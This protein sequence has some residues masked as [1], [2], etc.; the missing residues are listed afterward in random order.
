MSETARIEKQSFHLYVIHNHFQ[1]CCHIILKRI[2]IYASININTHQH[3]QSLNHR[4]ML[5]HLEPLYL[6]HV[7]S[8][9][10]ER[11][12]VGTC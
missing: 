6:Y 3:Y 5:P 8:V 11:I 1:N 10:D 4:Q 2:Q 12:K 7:K 9:S